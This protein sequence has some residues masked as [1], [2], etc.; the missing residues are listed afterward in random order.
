ME[1]IKVISDLPDKQ[2]MNNSKVFDVLMFDQTSFEEAIKIDVK[3][4][5]N[6]TI[7][8]LLKNQSSEEC[9]CLLPFDSAV[10]NATYTLYNAG[11]EAFTLQT[12]ANTLFGQ[13]K[14]RYSNNL[15]TKIQQSLNKLEKIFVNLDCRDE[16]RDNRK[17]CGSWKEVYEGCLLSLEQKQAFY[18]SNGNPT[19][20][21]CFKEQS[22]VFEYAEHRKQIIQV[23]SAYFE[24]AQYF[25]DTIESM[26]I[27]RYVIRRVAQITS[28]NALYSHKL[29]LY[30]EDRSTKTTKGLFSDLG[31]SPTK[32]S[33]WRDKKSSLLTK[34]KGVLTLLKELDVIDDYSE[35]RERNKHAASIPIQGLTIITSSSH[36]NIR[37]KPL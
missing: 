20:A 28:E 3:V 16:Y 24:T 8:M 37:D 12:L 14:S 33:G 6:S 25:N 27:K 29:S 21:Y 10:M 11:Y 2:Y 34:I 23:P 9:L 7:H 36:N 19:I 35:Y 17:D 18:E 31:Y 5:K 15:L 4:Q 1:K 13:K 26:L 32:T 30:W 22:P